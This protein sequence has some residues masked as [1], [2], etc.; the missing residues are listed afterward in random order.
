[1]SRC[2]T[3]SNGYFGVTFNAT[4]MLHGVYGGE[5]G[6][7]VNPGDVLVYGYFSIFGACSQ[8]P[9]LIQTRSNTP[10]RELPVERW[11]VENLRLYNRALGNGRS[12]GV[13]KVALSPDDP[14]IAVVESQLVISFP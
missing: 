14:A 1:M 4:T 12:Q 10:T 7:P 9:I 13:L 3:L 2:F 5:Q 11:T 6:Q 8:Q